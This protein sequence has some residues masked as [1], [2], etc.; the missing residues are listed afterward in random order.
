MA[1]VA[2]LIGRI[3]ASP[4]IALFREPVKPES[5]HTLCAKRGDVYPTTILNPIPYPLRIVDANGCNI[6]SF[7]MLK[8]LNLSY[9]IR[10]TYDV[11]ILDKRLVTA[12][13]TVCG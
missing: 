5:T 6:Q 11:G 10:A 1:T 3:C 8:A 9:L 13:N 7:A 2:E 4:R 12:V